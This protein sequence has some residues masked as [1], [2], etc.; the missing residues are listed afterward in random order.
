MDRVV[1]EALIALNKGSKFKR[2]PANWRERI[3][4]LKNFLTVS[5]IDPRSVLERMAAIKEGPASAAQ[6][7]FF[8]DESY[9][10]AFFLQ[11][12]GCRGAGKAATKDESFSHA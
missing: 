11:E 10:V 5:I 6:V 2:K 4:P 8:L 3:D 12:I 7:G 9:F 1:V